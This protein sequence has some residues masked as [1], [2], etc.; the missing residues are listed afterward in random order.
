MFGF[1]AENMNSAAKVG[2][3]FTKAGETFHKL[4]DMTV[5]LDPV[6][7]ELNNLNQ[8]KTSHSGIN[9]MKQSNGTTK[10]VM[11]VPHK[12]SSS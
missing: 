4:A 5:M 11:S 6:A 9:V 1:L 3:I 12:S 10:I 2:E 8:P 7:Q